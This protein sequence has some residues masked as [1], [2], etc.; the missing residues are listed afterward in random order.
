METTITTDLTQAD[1][2]RIEQGDAIALD[3]EMGGL[4]PHRD[5]IYLI[6]VCDQDGSVNI[7]RSENWSSAIHLKAILK[8]PKIVKVIQFAIMDCAFLLKNMGFVPE[9][10]YCTKIASKIARTYSSGHS[11]ANLVNEFFGISLD[12]KQQMSFWG[13]QTLKQD[14]IEYSIGDVKYLLEI[15]KRLETILEKKGM[16]PTGISYIELNQQCQSM[17]PTLVN[18]WV[19][20]WDFGKED[21]ENVFGR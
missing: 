3:I 19:N 6:Q 16:L 13:D 8:N 11:L 18:L 5:A 12:K 9:N 7:L 17:I 4:N 15:R 21:Q 2:A 10:I 14:Q 20:G 1:V